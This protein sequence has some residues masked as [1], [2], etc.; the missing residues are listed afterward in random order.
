MAVPPTPHVLARR[1]TGIG[2]PAIQVLAVFVIASSTFDGLAAEPQQP[3]P[4]AEF[5]APCLH[6][7][8][9]VGDVA[10]SPDG[11]HCAAVC[12]NGEGGG[13]QV[14]VYRTADGHEVC[15][16]PTAASNSRSLAF[17]PGGDR[18]R[19]GSQ[20][21]SLKTRRQILEPNADRLIATTVDGARQLGRDSDGFV[22]FDV[23]KMAKLASIRL[24]ASASTIAQAVF[25]H[26][27]ERLLVAYAGGKS[28]V[29]DIER[30]ERLSQIA[31]GEEDGDGI[32]D[33][34]A[35][36]STVIVS[37]RTAVSV[38]DARTGRQ[39][40]RLI[41]GAAFSDRSAA[42]VSTDGRWLATGDAPRRGIVIWDLA[43]GQRVQR[44]SG[45][46]ASCSVFA[47]SKD[48]SKLL[49]GVSQVH[50]AGKLYLWDLVKG[51]QLLE[52]QPNLGGILHL[53]VSSDGRWLGTVAKGGTVAIWDLESGRLCKQ[54]EA[55][56]TRGIAFSSDSWLMAALGRRG[57]VRAWET[58]RWTTVID[59]PEDPQASEIEATRLALDQS[60]VLSTL[61]SGEMKVTRL[62][63]GR[64]SRRISPYTE[65]SRR[66]SAFNVSA[67][68]TQFVTS[69]GGTTESSRRRDQLSSEVDVWDAATMR[70][71]QSF[72]IPKSLAADPFTNGSPITD[73]SFLPGGTFVLGTAGRGTYILWDRPTGE[74]I[75][76]ITVSSGYL[77]CVTPDGA[78]LVLSTNSGF[79]VVELVTGQPFFIHDTSNETPASPI[80]S[81]RRPAITAGVVLADLRRL[82]TSIYDTGTV[83]VWSLASDEQPHHDSSHRRLTADQS[84]QCWTALAGN[85]AKRAYEAMWRLVDAG[86]DAITMI[87]ADL[88]PAPDPKTL[89][90]RIEALIGQLDADE[91]A[92]RESAQAD[93]AALA[94]VAAPQ[95]SAALADK[96]G[97]ERKFRLEALLKRVPN[98]R[99]R[100]APDTL[101]RLRVIQVLERIGGEGA[102]RQLERLSRGAAKAIETRQAKHALARLV[103]SG[104][105][106][107][108][109]RSDH[110]EYDR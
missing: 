101:R 44:L 89:R 103:A 82:A 13:C 45:E 84:S 9:P 64:V 4:L 20:C 55:D 7:T 63:T 78:F 25:S 72:K 3:Q 70:R 8:G 92:K 74:F 17:T 109:P 68:G 53:A 58:D 66:V 40:H 21:W 42:A 39:R 31:V 29:W 106:T 60:L 108:S 75:S 23:A 104:R 38:L 51:K 79:A 90:S 47:F 95:M 27:G 52:G 62:A 105:A 77:L 48:C 100:F 30:G 28:E 14:L 5:G 97:P 83:Q 69:P 6:V 1:A 86:P 43:S 91:F 57:A 22:V 34:S 19:Y 93:L 110:Q 50:G 81:F 107:A 15:R 11:T 33:L 88:T 35:D 10:F 96:P 16:F 41:T 18:L 32:W 87:A 67:D 59:L 76:E 98:S 80:R 85:D 56:A 26:D 73:V 49:A 71:V 99:A 24:P 2:W 94:G 102:A 46:A 36:G 61:R 65:P 54:L 12:A 37:S